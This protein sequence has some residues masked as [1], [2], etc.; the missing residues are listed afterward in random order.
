LS[1]F[2]FE[3]SRVELALDFGKNGS[4]ALGLRELILKPRKSSCPSRWIATLY[5][6]RGLTG[7][8]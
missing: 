7:Y 4:A 6:G 2:S 8:F 1:T 3:P 5:T